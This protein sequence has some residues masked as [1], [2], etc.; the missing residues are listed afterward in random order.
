V[1]RA[2]VLIRL[3]RHAEAA[4]ACRDVIEAVRMAGMTAQ[5]WTSLRLTAELLGDLGDAES[6]AAI[7]AAAD[8]DPL[9][10]VVM[11][12]DLERQANLRRPG[13]RPPGH[14]DSASVAAF[15][16]AELRRYC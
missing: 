11:G 6:A 2:S 5:V 3:R 4:A 13:A 1:A 14:G 15:A 12:P 7:V 8:A 10:P 16:L 9:A